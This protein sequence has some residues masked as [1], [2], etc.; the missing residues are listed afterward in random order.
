MLIYRL[1]LNQLHQLQRTHRSFTHVGSCSCKTIYFVSGDI[2]L[3]SI[4]IYNFKYLFR[5]SYVISFCIRIVEDKFGSIISS[6][7]DV[8][9]YFRILGFKHGIHLKV[10]VS[11]ERYQGCLKMTRNLEYNSERYQYRYNH[12]RRRTSKW[13]RYER[14]EYRN[15]YSIGSKTQFV[16]RFCS[17]SVY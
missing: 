3:K 17:H 12:L 6:K 5:S 14:C 7:C 13:R 8:K 1:V 15:K 16:P 9:Y 4:V 11:K 2:I 10:Q